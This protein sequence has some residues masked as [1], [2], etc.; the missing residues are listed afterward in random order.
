VQAVCSSSAAAEFSFAAR[1]RLAISYS[2]TSQRMSIVRLDRHGLTA[3]VADDAGLP[4]LWLPR[5]ARVLS[6]GETLCELRLVAR[7]LAR[8]NGHTFELTMQPSRADDDLTFW[9]AM[10]A[11]R[12]LYPEMPGSAEFVG[13]LPGELEAV[14]ALRQPEAA[15]KVP[16]CSQT[17]NVR[18]PNAARMPG[19]VYGDIGCEVLFKLLDN[20]DAL[21][22]SEWFES[23]FAEVAAHVRAGPCPADLHNIDRHR[24][25]T[26]VRV[27]FRY[28]WG[29]QAVER[30]TNEVCKHIVLE[31][32]RLFGM[33][34]HYELLD[35]RN[36]GSLRNGRLGCASFASP[37]SVHSFSSK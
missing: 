26:A 14:V 5:P 3:S 25:G 23:H 21:F 22:F 35:V 7:T 4:Q 29:S 30:A 36:D 27:A 32:E 18:R 1:A 19:A 12:H 15:S 8:P 28:R 17:T 10:R 37:L 16:N 11:R 34:L 31:A 20:N 6:G 33:S 24:A 9:Q 13:Q 2:D